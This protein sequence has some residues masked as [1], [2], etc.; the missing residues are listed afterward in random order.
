MRAKN[1]VSFCL[2]L[3]GCRWICQTR[4][5]GLDIAPS[6]TRTVTVSAEQGIFNNLV[7]SAVARRLRS[8]MQQFLLQTE[9]TY[10]TVLWD[11]IYP[12]NDQIRPTS[13]KIKQEWA[14]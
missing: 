4:H 12:N 13:K 3:Q 1:W 10:C 5:I 11:N 8:V 9:N 2:F 14:L 6:H 7:E